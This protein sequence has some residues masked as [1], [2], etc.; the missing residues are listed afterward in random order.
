MRA[1]QHRNRLV[2][3]GTKLAY[4]ANRT[5][6]GWNFPLEME[7]LGFRLVYKESLYGVGEKRI[8]IQSIRTSYIFDRL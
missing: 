4:K 3:Y 7:R 5:S 1:A 8:V 6:G 2:P